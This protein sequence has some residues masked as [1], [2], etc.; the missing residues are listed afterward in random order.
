MEGD[1]GKTG[2]A[3]GCDC[4]SDDQCKPWEDGM[5]GKCV[6]A[7]GFSENFGVKR[8]ENCE[9]DSNCRGK[10]T[11]LYTKQNTPQ[12]QTY[13]RTHNTHTIHTQHSTAQHSTAQHSTAHSHSHSFTRAHTHIHAHAL[14]HFRGDDAADTAGRG[15]HG[16]HVTGELAERPAVEL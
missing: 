12:A 13:T 6:E 7:W 1:G 5:S 10:I 15:D 9:S 16:A 14:T 4:E 3:A 11:I 2:R 8:C